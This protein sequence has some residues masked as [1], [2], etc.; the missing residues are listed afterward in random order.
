MIGISIKKI[1]I[2]DDNENNR[3]LL[4]AILEDYAEENDVRLMI[5]EAHNGLE[6]VILSESEPYDLIFMDIMMPEMDGIEATF[7]IRSSNAKVLIVAVS[8]VDDAE[9]QKEILSNGAED[10]IFKPINADIFHARVANYLSLIESRT[11]P[12]VSHHNP[13]ALNLYTRDVYNRKFIFYVDNDDHLAE[14]WEY[15]LLDQS[16][17]SD[18][19][20]DAVRA[21]YAIG[22]IGVKWKLKLRI[23]IE[24]SETE[25][26]MT[27]SGIEG[28]EANLVKLI[29]LK[30]PGVKEY[31]HEGDKFSISIPKPMK[32]TVSMVMPEAE[33]PIVLAPIEYKAENKPI[34][35]FNYMDQEDLEDLKGHIAAI[36]SLL[37]IVGSG[38]IEEHEVQEIVTYLDRIGHIASRYHESYPIGSILCLLASEIG[39]HV[40]EFQKNSRNLGPLCAAFGRDLNTWVNLVFTEG[41]TSVDFMDQ[42]IISNVNMIEAFLKDHDKQDGEEENLD[43]IFDF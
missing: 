17:G 34:Q 41:T 40:H 15:Y 43:D 23:I 26:Y 11:K 21:I 30:N 1:L 33:A 35:V 9:R 18:E 13:D 5:N 14:F 20:S 36:D 2:V 4:R 12:G 10:Y 19:L 24:E 27:I 8:A 28:V 25:L 6:A 29:M 37:M 38:D 31:L 32:K 42:T 22:G 7:R 3:V 39:E 16:L